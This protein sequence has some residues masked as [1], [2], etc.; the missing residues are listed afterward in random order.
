MFPVLHPT[1]HRK[2]ESKETGVPKPKDT[3]CASFLKI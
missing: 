1:C 3:R 2:P